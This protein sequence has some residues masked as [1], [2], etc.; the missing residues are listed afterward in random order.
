MLSEFSKV[1]AFSRGIRR[2]PAIKCFWGDKLCSPSGNYGASPCFVGWGN[3]PNTRQVVCTAAE[4]AIP[5]FRL[6]DGFIHSA[7]L[8]TRG[9]ASFSLVIDDLG[10]YYDATRPSRLEKILAEHDFGAD[11]Q[12]VEKAELAISLIKEFKIS[13]YNTINQAIAT[14]ITDS[15]RKKIL[16]IAQTAGDM[17]LEYGLG[18]QFSTSQIVNAAVQENPGA[19]IYLKIH[20]DVIA[21]KKK[22]DLD[23][24][25]LPAEC[26]VLARDVN[27]IS[28]LEKID[29]VYTK[30]SQMGFEALLLGKECV[31]F[32][33]P[34]YAG[35]GLTDDRVECHR[36][37]RKLTVSQVFAGA[38][39]LYSRYYNPYLDQETDIIDTIYAIKQ[40]RDT[41][42]S[43][44][45]QWKNILQWISLT[46]RSLLV[47][48]KRIAAAK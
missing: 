28:L 39:I 22:S 2:N 29:K 21:G 4:K 38:Y 44:L 15:S 48:T 14:D 8:G 13:K 37:N 45:S 26:R 20:P 6:E 41:L 18:S 1:V 34:F 5:Y 42:R 33:M 7:G 27:P 30:T 17:S 11:K 3:K 35:W 46:R 47:S 25:K 9:S 19:D 23:V 24:K 32:G 36:R 16:V 31:C 40:N 12:V 43:G 10:M